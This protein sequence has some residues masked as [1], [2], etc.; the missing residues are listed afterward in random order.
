MA[1]RKTSYTYYCLHC[2]RSYRAKSSRSQYCSGACRAKASRAAHGA[3]VD[4]QAAASERRN[5]TK[6]AQRFERV[7]SQ[8]GEP[9][10]AN[11]KQ[12]KRLYCGD[13]RKK[14]AYLAAHRTEKELR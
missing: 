4:D 1:T 11:G 3:I 9:F 14:R 7:C 8:C 12:G 5:A 10:T 13:K 6:S 2:H